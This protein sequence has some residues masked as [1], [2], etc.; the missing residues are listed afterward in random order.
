MDSEVDYE[1]R[2]TVV[3]TLLNSDD[4][5]DISKSLSGARKYVFQQFVPDHARLE[6]LRK[7]EPFD[8]ESLDTF[9]VLAKDK[10]KNVII[11]GKK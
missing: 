3:P 7:V 4:I 2:T 11:R 5:R 1:F 10:I 9:Y 8:N 6:R